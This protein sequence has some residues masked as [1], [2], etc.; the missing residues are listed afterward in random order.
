MEN[1]YN[2]AK[3]AARVRILRVE[4]GMSRSSFAREIGAASHGLITHW[5]SGRSAPT[6]YFLFQLAQTCGVSADWLLGLT[7]ERR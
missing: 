5:E 2:P 6:S 1:G 3:L 7:D 4:R